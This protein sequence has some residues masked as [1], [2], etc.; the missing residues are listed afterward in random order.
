MKKKIE[1][2]VPES[3]EDFSSIVIKAR[4][5]LE[6]S[7]VNVVWDFNGIICI[8]DRESNLDLVSR[9]YNDAF[10]MNWKTVGPVYL[11]DRGIEVESKIKKLNERR[12]LEESLETK[13]Y[14]LVR[15][16]I[17]KKKEKKLFK[18]LRNLANNHTDLKII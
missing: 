7:D 8:V 6:S 3:M 15:E 5:I 11:T 9:D 17:K 1:V 4:E 14:V 12:N 13:A 2:L 10:T 18:I 16:I